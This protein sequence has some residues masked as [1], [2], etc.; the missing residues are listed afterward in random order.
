MKKRRRTEEK[1]DDNE[2]TDEEVDEDLTSTQDFSKLPLKPDHDKRPIWVC[3]NGR[4]YLE[5]YS[6]VYKQ[7]YDFLIAIADPVSR[8]HHIHE[9]RVTPYSLYAAASLGLR[10]ED[11]ISGLNRLSKMELSEK[12][13][14]EI[15]KRTK[16]CGKVKLLLRKARYYVE[17]ADKSILTTLLRQAPIAEARIDHLP[18]DQ[19]AAMQEVL[20]E[21]K[22]HDLRAMG[23]F[24]RSFVCPVCLSVFVC[25]C[26]STERSPFDSRERTISLT[27]T[28]P[29][30]CPRAPRPQNP[31]QPRLLLLLSPERTEWRRKSKGRPMQKTRANI[32]MR[33]RAIW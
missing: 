6:P 15:V 2:L 17:S 33:S 31:H 5:T 20:P 16:T 25:L 21:R 4:V 1:K 23:S 30:T 11:I 26:P 10:T 24:V 29:S 32:A 3:P 13:K 27:L 22:Q 8:P 12:L 7:A 9:Y 19:R 18:P 14:A 28:Q